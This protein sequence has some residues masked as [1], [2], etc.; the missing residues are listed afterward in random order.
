M[1]QNLNKAL[2]KLY[3]YEEKLEN[4]DKEKSLL[5]LEYT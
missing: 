4:L 3:E 1:S 2:D 5:K